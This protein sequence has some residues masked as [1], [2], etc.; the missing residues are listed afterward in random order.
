[1]YVTLEEKRADFRKLKGIIGT[2]LQIASDEELK[3]VTGCEPDSAIPLGFDSSV[4]II[5]DEE[6]F[7]QKRVI[8]SPGPPGKT[9]VVS[10]EDFKKSLRPAGM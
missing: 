3:K 7:K 1:M 6:V 4:G 5:L 8:F 10:G 2:K 9:V